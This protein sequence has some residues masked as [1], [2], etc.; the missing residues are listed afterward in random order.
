MV[1]DRGA[2]AYRRPSAL[3]AVAVGGA[4]GTL[5][6][7]YAGLVFPS[8]PHGWPTA[9]FAVNVVGAFALGLLLEAL[10][11]TGPDTGRRYLLRLAAGTGLLGAFTTYSTFAVEVTTFGRDGNLVLAA[12]YAVLSVILGVCAAGMGIAVGARLARRGAS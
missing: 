5:G 7:Y 9:T 4:L 1:D 12:S 11:R 6:R 8:S 2:A 3:A 10:L